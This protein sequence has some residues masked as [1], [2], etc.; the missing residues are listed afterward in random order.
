MT[1][2]ADWTPQTS[3]GEIG[4]LHHIMHLLGR[5]EEGQR[6]NRETAE[7]RN[8]QLKEHFDFRLAEL[9]RE[10]GGRIQYLEKTVQR[11]QWWL[12]LPWKHMITFA[13]GAY[14]I[15]MGHFSAAELK[16]IFL[17]LLGLL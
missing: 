9:K 3:G 12:S 10:F 6:L 17:R 5:L 14:L 8:D 15:V 11:G 4:L 7:Q 2:S 13:A 16:A 1:H